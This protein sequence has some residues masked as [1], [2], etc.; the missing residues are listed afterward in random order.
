MRQTNEVGVC[1][2]VREIG[3]GARCERAPPPSEHFPKCFF[4][5]TIDY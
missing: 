5:A 1:L 3:G 2:L 4:Y